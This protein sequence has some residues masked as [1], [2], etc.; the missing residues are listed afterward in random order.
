MHASDVANT[1][2]DVQALYLVRRVKSA[3]SG[4][5]LAQTIRWFLY[6][7]SKQVSVPSTDSSNVV[8]AFCSIL[9]QELNSMSHSLLTKRLF[10]PEMM[11]LQHSITTMSM[12]MTMMIMAIPTKAMAN[13][14]L[15]LSILLRDYTESLLGCL[16]L[17][18]I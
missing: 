18:Q 3:G 5:S 17:P 16:P 14:Y 12:M 7:R 10:R 13:L 1:R 6:L 4:V 11:I 8:E 15:Q 9:E 2:S